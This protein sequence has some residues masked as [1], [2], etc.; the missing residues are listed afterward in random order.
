MMDTH[1]DK[2]TGLIAVVVAIVIAALL[3]SWILPNHWVTPDEGAHMMSAWR[4]HYGEVPLVDYG[5][6]QPLYCYTHALSQLFFGN[7]LIAGRMVSLLSTLFAGFLIFLIGKTVQGGVVGAVAAIL[8]LFSPLTLEY[9]TVVQTQPLVLVFSCAAVLVLL[10]RGGWWLVLSG[11]LAACAFYVRESSLAVAFAALVWIFF[12]RGGGRS[13]LRQGLPFMAGF[14]GVVLIVMLFYTQW[15]SASDIWHSNINPLRIGINAFHKLVSFASPESET[16]VVLVDALEREAEAENKMIGRPASFAN[17]LL[18]AQ[19]ICFILIAAVGT[20]ILRL[21]D[22]NIEGDGS[23]FRFLLFWLAWLS[24]LYGYWFAARGFFPGYLRE[25]EPALAILAATGLTEAVH[26]IG[27]RRILVL[28]LPILML[29]LVPLPVTTGKLPFW[30]EKFTLAVC[31][32]FAVVMLLCV[33]EVSWRKARLPLVVTVVILG[34]LFYLRRVGHPLAELPFEELL[35]TGAVLA[36]IAGM[37]LRWSGVK[38]TGPRL[39]LGATA[40]G[41]AM[42]VIGVAEKGGLD[43]RGPW[44]VPVVKTVAEMI[45]ENT[46]PGDEIMSGGVVWSYLADRYPYMQQ[47]HPL[48][49]YKFDTDSQE[50]DIFYRYYLENPPAIVVLDG[51]TEKTWYKNTRL[52]A[53]VENDYLPLVGAG[54]TG[55][56]VVMIHRSKK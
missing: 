54:S 43:F 14:A 39:L 51:M 24:I 20:L 16:R 40:F 35:L 34:V 15:L 10:S 49:F 37:L 56:V 13:L 53:A 46:E 25:F 21:R 52:K 47:N 38:D 7:T 18:A 48:G 36:T 50:V 22:R 32:G 27:I 17:L 44:P 31:S 12:M 6:R 8:F 30:V 28:S 3:Y 4:I 19:F 45:E 23:K 29:V 33:G 1:F 2:H 9:A 5:A 26:R 11:A 42:S 41:L 55:D